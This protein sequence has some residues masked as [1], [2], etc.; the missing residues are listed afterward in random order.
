MATVGQKSDLIS[1]YRAAVTDLLNVSD[2]LQ[3]LQTSI[4][5]LGLGTL[6]DA[7]FVG[8][9]AG[10]SPAEWADATYATALIVPA[11][12]GGQAASIARA[13]LERMRTGWQ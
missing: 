12:N 10:I 8:D 4:N 6:T 5:A 13:V 3:T 7:D 1:T 9:N 11:L 2:R